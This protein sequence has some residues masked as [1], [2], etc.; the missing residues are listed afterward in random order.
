MVVKTK[1][2]QL[3]TKKY[4]RMALGTT[5]KSMWW[6]FLIPLALGSLTWVLNSTNWW[7]ISAVILT[8]LFVLFWY[9][10]YTGITQLP[11]YAML[12]EKYQYEINSQQILMK[13]SAREGMP[14]QWNQI[15]SASLGKDAYTLTISRGQFIYLPHR[16]F[17]SQ[18][19]MKFFE[20]ILKRKSLIKE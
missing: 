19:D 13:K 6:A 7:W 15:K 12:F 18:N 5:L 4:V 16:I 3:E 8:V 2:Y 11:Q 17:N 10:Q 1:K 14:I 20:T 9:I